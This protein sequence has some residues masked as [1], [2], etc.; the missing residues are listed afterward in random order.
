[1]NKLAEA[2]QNFRLFLQPPG[3][4]KKAFTFLEEMRCMKCNKLLAKVKG[5]AEI[6][7]IRCK[8]YNSFMN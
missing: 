1:M 4:R 8:T 3:S 2:V 7:C 5:K 6:K